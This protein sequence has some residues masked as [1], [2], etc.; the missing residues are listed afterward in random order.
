VKVNITPVLFSGKH[1][2]IANPALSHEP[3]T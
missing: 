1:G 3:L 2:T